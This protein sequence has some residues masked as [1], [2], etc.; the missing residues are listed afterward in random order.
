MNGVIEV[1]LNARTPDDRV[2]LNTR[3]AQRSLRDQAVKPGDWLWLRDGTIRVGAQ[4]EGVGDQLLA[5]PAWETLEEEIWPDSVS[6][7]PV[8][9][10]EM[11]QHFRHLL[12]Q[13]PKNYRA[14]LKLL[15]TVERYAP[16]RGHIAYLR[17]RALGAL[18]H[19]RLALSALGEAMGREPDRPA[20]VH[21]YFVLLSEIDRARA[22][23]E[24][25]RI[26][27]LISSVLVVAAFAHVVN[28]FVRTL[29]PGKTERIDRQLLE[30]TETFKS[31]PDAEK[32]PSS[33][34]AMIHLA[35][36]YAHIRLGQKELGIREFG[37]AVAA[38]PADPTPLAARGIE[39]YPSEQGI[40]DLKLAIK[41]G[42]MNY[43]PF[44]YLT[45]HYLERGEWQE[46]EKYAHDTAAFLPPNKIIAN[47]L[48]WQAIARFE[49]GQDAARVRQSFEMALKFAPDNPRIRQNYGVF[50][51]L[52]QGQP[53]STKEWRFDR[54]AQGS[55]LD[56]AA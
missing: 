55:A 24:A 45:H 47:V 53:A 46:V 34:V 54:D 5:R 29:G 43:W 11:F 42:V 7:N 50:E 3:G 4:I 52:S 25:G 17:S 30:R 38:K 19:P 15:T 22:F 21:Q 40:A 8:Q 16:D 26:G 48:E 9:V 31:A 13:T 2:R 27:N 56:F 36:G 28:A 23:E 33:A 37:M 41:L 44:Y 39:L 10:Q 1:D 51:K 35:R 20:F 6:P 14:I 12:A 32:A 18:G 49:M